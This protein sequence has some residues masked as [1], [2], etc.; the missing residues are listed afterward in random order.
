MAN[1]K[2]KTEA[3]AITATRPI[4]ALAGCV[5]LTVNYSHPS[6][7]VTALVLLIAAELTDGIDGWWARRKGC[8]SDIGKFLDPLCDS[9]ARMLVFICYTDFGW[10]PMWMLAVH[11]AR[12]L[13]VAEVRLIALSGKFVMAARDSGKA[14]AVAQGGAQYGM[15][16]VLL[17]NHTESLR[18]GPDTQH[19][20]YALFLLSTVVTAWSALDYTYHG[21]RAY[22][23]SRQPSAEPMLY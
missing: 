21:V 17:M 1:I 13:L 18:W 16:L 7:L 12:D 8:V 15:L 23:N 14:K 11:L 19:G 3:N 9:L 10:M 5:V 20:I 2:L 4:L 22:Q 6:Y